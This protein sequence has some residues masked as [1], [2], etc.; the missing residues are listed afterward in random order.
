[1]LNRLPQSRLLLTPPRNILA[2][3]ADEPDGHCI[4]AATEVRYHLGIGDWWLALLKLPVSGGAERHS[5]RMF[6]SSAIRRSVSH[7]TLYTAR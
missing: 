5:R 7:Q 3:F 2:A 1:M 4:W 6:S